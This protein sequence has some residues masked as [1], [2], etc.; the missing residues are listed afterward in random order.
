MKRVYYRPAGPSVRALTGVALLAV[1]LLTAVEFFPAHI[2]QGGYEIRVRASERAA[3]AFE[4]L[5]E[6]RQKRG[7][8]ID[9]VIDPAGT[10]LLGSKATVVTTA[11][12]HLTSKR[13]SA[14]PNF[15]AVV[16]AY[17]RRLQVA[18]GDLV[19]VGY[20]GS[21]PALNVAVLSAVT[22]MGLEPLIIA[23][24]TASDYG[25][26]LPSFMWLDME[27]VLT[28]QKVF[29]ARSLAA[30]VGGIEDQ[31]LG[32]S[33]EGRNLVL[34]VIERNRVPLIAEPSFKASLEERM[35][36]YY[37]AAR[38]R[39][40][41]AYINVGGGAVSVGRSR[42]KSYIRPGINR[43]GPRLPVDSIVGRF[44]ERGVPVIHLSHITTIASQFGLPV[45]PARPARVGQGEVF[46]QTEPNRLLAAFSL[47]SVLLALGLIGY[48]SRARAHLASLPE[49]E[50]RDPREAEARRR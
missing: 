44:L 23:S 30:S 32:L 3:R 9:P 46:Q 19:A 38:G 43:P 8:S 40:F 24:A 11:T 14:N 22:E 34:E 28:A 18:P 47:A 7:L 37:V 31:G 4:V 45:D 2:E 50:E 13:T 41:A 42:G 10:G 49:G 20:S 15:A 5:R 12:G 48:R 17:L 39:T 27:R 29:S 6:E 35:R 1:S 33:A 36:L 21:F 25:A 16:V 26:N